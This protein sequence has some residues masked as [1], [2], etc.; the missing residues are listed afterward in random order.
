M[1]IK[2][3][4]EVRRIIAAGDKQGNAV[5]Y[6]DKLATDVRTDPA[7]PG[8]AFT[9]FWVTEET[10]APIRGVSDLSLIHI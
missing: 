6:E 8:F 3:P 10:P 7:R 1:P 2:D 5:I 4:R 9:R